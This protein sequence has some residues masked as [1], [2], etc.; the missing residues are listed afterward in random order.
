V[1]LPLAEF[2]R[3]SVALLVGLLIGLD[4]ERA[5]ARKQRD[6]FAG[7]RTFP[8]IALA[9]AVPAS[10]MTSWGAVPLIASFSALAALTVVA[11]HRSTRTGYIGATTEMAA[12]VTF[13]LGALAG[14]GY[15][16]LAGGGGIAVALLLNAK[17]RLEGFS[18]ALSQQEVDAALELGVISC[19]VLPLLPNE[20]LG[21]WHAWN[22]FEIWLV[23]VSV[24]ALSFGGFVAMRLFGSARGLLI[25]GVVGALVSS[26]AVTVAMAG[27]SRERPAEARIAAAAAT[28]ASVV[29]CWRVLAFAAGAG[30]IA[31]FPG[32]LPSIVLMSITGL[33]VSYWL[34]HGGVSRTTPAEPATLESPFSLKQAVVFGLIYSLVLVVMPA[35]RAYIGTAG[36]YVVAA[37]SSLLDV[38]AITIA[39]S[40][41]VDGSLTLRDATAS[42]LLA[43]IVN[44]LFKLGVAVIM[45]EAVF[46][47]WV[48]LGL[49]IMAVVGAL[50]ATAVLVAFD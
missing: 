40:R 1:A 12:L 29:M 11:Y 14:S 16:L 10:R 43:V 34:S 4:R 19:I 20:G 9:G 47:R 50:A 23:V 13:F 7:I 33:I 35:A 32:L 6:L 17:P 38:D 46:R 2:V 39:I 5:E 24:S 41:N 25:S 48:G 15:E 45:G 31:L 37:L 8:L 30:G 27:R 36:T 3:L 42:V 22:P 18:R 21:P 49:G 44:T 28:L 26:T